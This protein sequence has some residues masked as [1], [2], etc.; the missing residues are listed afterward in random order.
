MSIQGSCAGDDANS[1]FH[2]SSPILTI[3]GSP[4]WDIDNGRCYLQWY[5]VCGSHVFAIEISASSL[6]GGTHASIEL[7]TLHIL[8]CQISCI[9]Q[10]YCN[11]LLTLVHRH[12]TTPKLQAISKHSGQSTLTSYQDAHNTWDQD[13]AS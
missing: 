11:I 9:K 7:P 3:F 1:H 2:C 4:S 13:L 5:G 10:Q 12:N 8:N 6:F